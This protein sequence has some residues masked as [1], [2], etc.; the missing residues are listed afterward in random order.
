MAMSASSGPPPSSLNFCI[1]TCHVSIDRRFTC[2]SPLEVR[3]LTLASSGVKSSS[4]LKLRVISLYAASHYGHDI[5]I[6]YNVC[7]LLSFCMQVYVRGGSGGTGAA[8]FKVMA[9]KQRGQA[10]GGSGGRGGD[11]TLVRQPAS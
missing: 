3:M 7:A 6:I 8:T 4:P 1:V 11:V 5:Y 10:N 9:K 2:A